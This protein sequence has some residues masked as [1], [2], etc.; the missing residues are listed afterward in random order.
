MQRKKFPKYFV[1][2]A[3]NIVLLRHDNGVSASLNELVRNKEI[4]KKFAR[5]LHKQLKRSEIDFNEVCIQDYPFPEELIDKEGVYFVF[6]MRP[7]MDCIKGL[8]IIDLIALVLFK[9]RYR[10]SDHLFL[11]NIPSYPIVSIS[12]LAGG[13]WFGFRKKTGVFSEIPFS[14]F[15]KL[16]VRNGYITVLPFCSAELSTIEV[17]PD[18]PECETKTIRYTVFY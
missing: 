9:L 12:M 7:L 14:E 16:L 10:L 8:K 17:V 1:C 15:S 18:D 2:P 11:N 4:P 6:K 5:I 3:K 13:S